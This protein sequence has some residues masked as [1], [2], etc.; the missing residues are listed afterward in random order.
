MNYS[1]K[2][3]ICVLISA[4]LI[5]GCLILGVING[6]NV[7]PEEA[8]DAL[9][10]INVARETITWQ[11]IFVNNLIIGAVALIPFMGVTSV[12]EILYNTGFMI[13]EL[14]KANNAN[15]MIYLLSIV[16]GPSGMLETLAYIFAFSISI[17]WIF[18]IYYY[19]RKQMTRSE[20]LHEMMRATLK[21]MAFTIAFL[22]VSSVIEVY[23]IAGVVR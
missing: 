3:L 7:R 20:F 14:A 19:L 1:R 2:F 11:E 21:A 4:L 17:L 22:L 23:N 8:S 15:V 18:N 5:Y 12:L 13:G 10:S 9:A 16:L 6:G